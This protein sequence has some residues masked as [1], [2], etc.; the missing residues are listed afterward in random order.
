[1]PEHTPTP[2]P[3]RAVYGFIMYLSFKML[4]I[5]F[6]LWAFVPHSWFRSIGITYLPQ[7]YWAVTIPIFLL[8]VLATFAFVI[9]PCL[10]LQ[11]TPDIDSL[12]TISDIHSRFNNIKENECVSPNKSVECC[13]NK[14]KCKKKEFEK[15]CSTEIFNTQSIPQLYDLRITDV[16]NHLY[17]KLSN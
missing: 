1:M 2:T 3:S 9:Y 11:M 6:V 16:S 4:F 5:L 13:R 7:R 8:T 12:D 14:R 10:G 17:K 15:Q